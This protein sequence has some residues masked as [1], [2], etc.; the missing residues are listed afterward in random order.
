MS[1]EENIAF[2]ERLKERA[3]VSSNILQRFDDFEIF[4]IAPVLRVF[5]SCSN[6]SLSR[7]LLCNA[8]NAYYHENENDIGVYARFKIDA[9][10]SQE[11]QREPFFDSLCNFAQMQYPDFQVHPKKKNG[12][13]PLS[14]TELGQADNITLVKKRPL[15]EMVTIESR[16]EYLIETCC[17]VSDALDAFCNIR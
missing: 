6:D 3:R 16:I 13:T 12:Y 2:L 1:T 4:S 14:A 10:E 9:L 11:I 7:I 8:V 15:T 17:E 5:R